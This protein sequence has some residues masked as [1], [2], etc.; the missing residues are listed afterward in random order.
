MKHF[1]RKA[2]V[3]AFLQRRIAEALA[4]VVFSDE[5][6]V[7]QQLKKQFPT[8]APEKT[9]LIFESFSPRCVLGLFVC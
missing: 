2:I 1:Q 7:L 9:L 3:N 5:I 8:L 6:S 4:L